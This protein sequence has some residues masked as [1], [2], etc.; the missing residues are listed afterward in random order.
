MRER[1]RHLTTG[2][3]IYGAGDV[4]VALTG[5]LLIPIYIRGGYLVEADYGALAILVSIETFLKVLFRWGL[6]GAFMRYY[7]ERG[8]EAARQRLASTILWFLLA[9]DVVLLAL[10]LG[11]SGA[12]AGALFDADD[13]VTALRKPTIQKLLDRGDIQLGLF[14]Q[15][16]LVEIE[17]TELP[18]S[19]LVVCRNP[20]ER[21][22]QRQRRQER[23]NRAVAALAQVRDAVTRADRPLRHPDR[24]RGRRS[25]RIHCRR[26]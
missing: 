24:R 7:L 8:D 16:S 2:V 12:L 10:L 5:L 21:D 13:Y 14:D 19:R 15:M 26:E 17:S 23:V 11:F 6:D 3:A 18:G 20:H 4:I 22:A 9:I 1:L 25:R